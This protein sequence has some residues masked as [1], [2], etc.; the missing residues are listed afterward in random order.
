MHLYRSTW[1]AFFLGLALTFGFIAWAMRALSGGELQKFD[2]DTAVALMEAAAGHHGR[3]EFMVALTY[4]ASV[5]AMALLA[6]VGAIWQ[7][8]RRDWVLAIGWVAIVAS[9]G[10]LDLA[11]KKSLGRPRPPADWR[12]EAIFET[13]ESFPSGHSMGG[14][15]GYGMLAYAVLPLLRRRALKLA[16]LVFIA[17]LIGLVGFSRIYLRAHWFSDVVGGFLIGGAWL[18][19]GLAWVSHCRARAARS[20]FKTETGPT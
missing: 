16:W 5:A 8:L 13:N 18:S 2:N 9:G 15:I 10:L 12:D 20:C 11:L 17:A 14:L 6:L 1:I 19:F 4:M 3:R 7:S